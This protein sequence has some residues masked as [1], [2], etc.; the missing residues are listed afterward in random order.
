[1]VAPTVTLDVNNQVRRLL[2]ASDIMSTHLK[3]RIGSFE[4]KFGISLPDRDTQEVLYGPVLIR[5]YKTKSGRRDHKRRN[6][7]STFNRLGSF[8]ED[9]GT[10]EGPME[11]SWRGHDTSSRSR[12]LP[13]FMPLKFDCPNFFNDCVTFLYIT[14]VRPPVNHGNACLPNHVNH[15]VSYSVLLSDQSA[16]WSGAF[17]S[18]ALED[19]RPSTAGR[20]CA[21][22]AISRAQI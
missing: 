14:S 10:V 8:I 6:T 4:S 13:G 1:M 19:G 5:Q 18:G 7:G 16:K 9:F 22:S 15:E 2:T 17:D 21:R 12:L 3:T 11:L 20:R